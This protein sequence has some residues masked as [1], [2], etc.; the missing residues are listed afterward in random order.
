MLLAAPV[1]G[2]FMTLDCDVAVLGG[3]TSALAAALTAATAAPQLTVCLTDPT[4]GHPHSGACFAKCFTVKQKLSSLLC[5]AAERFKV[6]VGKL[7]LCL[8]LCAC[9]DWLGG[10]MTASGVSAIDFGPVNYMYD[11]F[12]LFVFVVLLGSFTLQ[13]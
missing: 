8:G 13:R 1:A 10:Q 2:R 4:Y 9:R 11:I 5:G 3:S 6:R 12:C 7:V